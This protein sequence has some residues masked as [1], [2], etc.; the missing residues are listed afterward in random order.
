MVF[1]TCPRS[2]LRFR[3]RVKNGGRGNKRLGSMHAEPHRCIPITL[4]N[5]NSNSVLPSKQY[6][7]PCGD[8]RRPGPWTKDARDGPCECGSLRSQKGERT[9]KS[10][11]SV[12][13]APLALGFKVQ[14]K[15]TNATTIMQQKKMYKNTSVQGESGKDVALALFHLP[16]VR[17]TNNKGCCVRCGFP[18]ACS[19]HALQ[20]FYQG[21]GKC[22][23]VRKAR[24]GRL[25]V[26]YSST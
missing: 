7:K 23:C 8:E 19:F 16:S 12:R 5:S 4:E 1:V 14:S 6:S 20:S 26:L 17:A 2:I 15:I 24:F 21:W 10:R 9:T 18:R 11:N 25:I 13:R 22:G 3:C